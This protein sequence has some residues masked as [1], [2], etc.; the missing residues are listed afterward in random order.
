M[1]VMWGFPQ[2]SCTASASFRSGGLALAARATAGS[3]VLR[4]G[5]AVLAHARLG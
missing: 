2:V 1:L 3:A 4:V 5:Y